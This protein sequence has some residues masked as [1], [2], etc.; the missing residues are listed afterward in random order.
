VGSKNSCA[1][2]VGASSRSESMTLGVSYTELDSPELEAQSPAGTIRVLKPTDV[3]SST[4]IA[5][6][7]SKRYASVSSGFYARFRAHAAP[8]RPK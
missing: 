1:E 6:W 7:S 2:R 3:A 8:W 4:K 5:I